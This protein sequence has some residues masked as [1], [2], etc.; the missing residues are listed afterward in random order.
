MQSEA[1]KR[2]HKGKNPMRKDNTIKMTEEEALELLRERLFHL[3][4]RTD[5]F[6]TLFRSMSGYAIIATDFDGNIQ[7]YNEEVIKFY[8]YT[9]E[10]IICGKMNIDVFFSKDFIETGG[11]QQII[12][13]TME[14]GTCV[15]DGDNVRKD[16]SGFPVQILLALVKNKDGVMVGF[17][18]IIQDLTEHK[19]REEEIKK[20][21]EELERRV[22]ERT[23]QLDDTVKKLEAEILVRKRAEDEIKESEEKLRIIASS[24]GDAVMMIDDNGLITFWNEAAEKIFGYKNDEAMGKNIHRLIVPEKYYNDFEKG[25]KGFRKT[26]Q[27]AVIGKTQDLEAKSKDGMEFFTEHTISAVNIKGKWHAIGVARDITERKKTEEMQRRQREELQ[28]IIESS[29]AMIFYKDTENKFIRVNNAFSE[30]VRLPKEALV[31]KSCFDVFPI[32][33]ESYWKD[34]KEVM[35]SGNPKTGIIEQIETKKGIRWIQTDKVPYRD[36]KGKIAGVIGFAVDITERKYA[37]D[38]LQRSYVKLRRTLEETAISLSSA[39]EMRDAYT[40]G[41]Q[42]RVTQLACA[43]AIELGLSEEQIEGIKVAGSLHDIG[44]ISIPAEILCKP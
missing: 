7:T 31:E 39:L 9:H 40:A 44:K 38:N 3:R 6:D 33:A 26:G 11:L 18:E 34:D 24:A 36:E 30:C 22:V 4:E 21:N 16:G 29:P 42:R 5:F 37:E 43:I 13:K 20:L 41:H 10:E 8:G 35:T 23:A 32:H 14:N 15:F 27:G 28:T 2:L 17:I 12:G 1:A 19:R 25:F